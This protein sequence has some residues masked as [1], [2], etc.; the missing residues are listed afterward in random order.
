VKK[1]SARY[2][3][4]AG[5]SNAMERGERVR[6]LTLTSPDAAGLTMK[7]LY[8]SW[9]RLA[10]KLRRA[11]KLKEYLAVIE[12]TQAGALHL[13]VLATGEYINQAQLSRLAERAGFGPIAD[14]RAVRGT[15]E[16]SAGAY[17]VKALAGYA[18]KANVEALAR[19]GAKRIRPVRVSRGWFPGGL[20]E[21]HRLLSRELTGGG[22]SE[23]DPGPW[24]WVESF[25]DGFIRVRV[26]VAVEQDEGEAD[27]DEARAPP[28]AIASGEEGGGGD[29]G[30]VEAAQRLA[31]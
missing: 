3:I 8:E 1:A 10:L 18:T 27:D 22:G 11:G 15:G 6:F 7:G 9:N 14:I 2:L 4:E 13:H 20:T 24:L 25:C 26:R 29:G 31:A 5:V 21:A 17:L 12:T 30:A 28:P 19:K 23:P 16:R